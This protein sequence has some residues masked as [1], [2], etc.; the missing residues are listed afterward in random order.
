QAGDA[1]R[2][3]CT[4]CLQGG[5]RADNTSGK[6]KHSMN[7]HLLQQFPAARRALGLTIALGVLGTSAT[8]AQMLLLSV[9]VSRVFLE[10]A[11]LP[12]LWPLLL[13]LA[14]VSLARAAASGGRSLVAQRSAVRVKS[15]LRAQLFA[16]LLRL[17]PAYSRS[18]ATGE[19]V[20]TA[21]EGVERLDAYMS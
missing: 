1:E 6:A 5:N 13:L 3:R 9:V 15:A 19:L 11:D 20:T 2:A 21:V 16:H 8:V 17:G 12:A 7:A 10:R 4:L 14:G 18:M